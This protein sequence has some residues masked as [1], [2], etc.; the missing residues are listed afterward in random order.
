MGFDDYYGF[1]DYLEEK[2]KNKELSLRISFMSQPVGQE[3]NIPYGL[4]MREKFSSDF[5]K[6]SDLIG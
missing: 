5:V 3:I 1:T 6:F 4:K 2:E